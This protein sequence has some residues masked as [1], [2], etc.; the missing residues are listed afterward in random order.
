LTHL[1][2]AGG[3]LNIFSRLASAYSVGTNTAGNLVIT[4]LGLDTNSPARTRAFVMTVAALQ[5]QVVPRPTVTISG[6]YP[7]GFTFS[8]PTVANPGLT[9]YL[10]YSTDLTP[11]F[12]WATIISTP[13]TGSIATLPDPNPPDSQRFYRVRVQ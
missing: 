12:A 5:A 8:F 10:E 2:V 6:S 9:Y 11:P 13:G 1:A 7:A 4:G 3:K